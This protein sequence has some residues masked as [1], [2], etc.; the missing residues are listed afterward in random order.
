MNTAIKEKVN[1]FIENKANPII[2]EIGAHYGEDTIDMLKVF[3]KPNIFCFEPHPGNAAFMR[4]HFGMQKRKQFKMEFDL[5]EGSDGV[6][7]LYEIALS[8]CDGIQN[9]EFNMIISPLGEAKLPKKYEWMNE[10]DYRE[11]RL[12][13]SGG[14][15]LK[16]GY[17]NE[18]C[19]KVIVRTMCLDRWAIQECMN[20]ERKP[21]DERP[22]DFIWMDVQGAEKDV[23]DGANGTLQK[24]KYVWTEFGETHYDGGM[25]KQET[26]A[27]FAKIGFQ[28]LLSDS[29]NLLMGII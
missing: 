1:A 8:N 16:D 20:P 2:L 11:L 22:I 29:N 4:K 24:T 14:S 5:Y 25:T 27:M 26:I 10:D 9:A 7:K 15:S 21:L 3:N 17:R 6:I 13:D 12:N 19:E 28:P 18:D 23:I